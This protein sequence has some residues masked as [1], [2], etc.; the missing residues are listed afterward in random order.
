MLRS[1]GFVSFAV[2]ARAYPHRVSGNERKRRYPYAVND[3]AGRDDA[4]MADVRAALD[5]RVRA[6]ED[7]IFEGYRETR[8]LRLQLQAAPMRIGGVDRDEGRNVAVVADPHVRAV[9]VD[10]GKCADVNPLADL[11][12]AQDPDQRV[13]R[14]CLEGRRRG[15]CLEKIAVIHVALLRSRLRDSPW[16]RT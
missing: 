14:I 5:G 3:R 13:K 15:E 7:V 11:G 9:C 8:D 2:V 4:V 6:H 10:R 1:R 12:V 16:R